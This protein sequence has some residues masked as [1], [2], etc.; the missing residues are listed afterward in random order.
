MPKISFQ[1]AFQALTL[2]LLFMEIVECLRQVKHCNTDQTTGLGTEPSNK[3]LVQAYM[4]ALV[5][6]RAPNKYI[7]TTKS[8]SIRCEFVTNTTLK[9]PCI[10]M[11]L[12][13]SLVKYGT[14]F[15]AQ[16]VIAHLSICQHNIH[17][18]APENLIA[19]RIQ[20]SGY[21]ACL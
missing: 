2:R 18:S 21:T 15:C 10:C 4:C 6:I 19:G 13:L 7:S 5:H 16:S 12:P 9:T 1:G 20:I 8:C 17:L 11:C 3:N 14:I